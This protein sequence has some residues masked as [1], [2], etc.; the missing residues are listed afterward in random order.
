M[1]SIKIFILL[2]FVG[3][4]STEIYAQ[5]TDAFFRTADAFFKANVKNGRVDYAKVKVNPETLHK[6]LE[7]ASKIKVSTSDAKTYQ[8]FWINTYNLAVIKGIIEK[9][10]V[11]Q[12][13]SIKG[14]FDK[15]KYDVGGT[16]ITLND[17]ENKMLRAKFPNEPRFHFALVCAGLGCPPIIDEAYTPSKLESQLQ[18]QTEIAVNN[19]NF[20]KVK[21]NKVQLSQIFEWYKEDFVRNGNEIDFLNKYRKE[22]IPANAKLSYYPYDWTL[23]DVK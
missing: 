20:I 12:P 19:P 6:L 1:K 18:R 23:N 2:L 3:T 5:D 10:P 9:Y 21:G 8:A 7:N 13:L 15:N 22:P 17:I 14:F 16:S 4:L 11:K